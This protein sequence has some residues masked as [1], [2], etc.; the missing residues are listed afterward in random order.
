MQ[1]SINKIIVS[2]KKKILESFMNSRFMH[3]NALFGVD[4]TY[5]LEES[6]ESLK[7]NKKFYC[8]LKPHTAPSRLKV[9]LKL[10]IFLSDIFYWHR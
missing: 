1:V 3:K 6:S 7:F 9:L 8:N 4:Y 2:G 5:G 10:D